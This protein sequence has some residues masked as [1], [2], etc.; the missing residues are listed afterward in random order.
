MQS[1]PSQPRTP[2]GP[3]GSTPRKRPTP[4]VRPAPTRELRPWQLGAFILLGLA[5][6][7]LLLGFG[8]AR[9]FHQEYGQYP[10]AKSAVPPTMY[11][12]HWKY[13]PATTPS[14]TNPVK[15]G[16]TPGGGTIYAPSTVKKPAPTTIEVRS[17][18]TSRTYTI[19]PDK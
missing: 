5:V 13:T 3:S 15:V 8:Y 2:S 16:T 6:A 10:W 4:P 1:M 7:G 17:G 12:D 14:L 9:K 18:S 19:A 11:Y